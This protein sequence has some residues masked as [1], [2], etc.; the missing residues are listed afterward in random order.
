MGGNKIIAQIVASVQINAWSTPM[1]ILENQTI[2]EIFS[3]QMHSNATRT[4][5]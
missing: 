3:K 2:F 5:W 1:I 4:K